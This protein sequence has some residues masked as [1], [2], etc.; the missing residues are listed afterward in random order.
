MSANVFET[1]EG[2][3]AVNDKNQVL[4]AGDDPIDSDDELDQLMEDFEMSES[5]DE[6]DGEQ[7]EKLFLSSSEEEYDEDG[8]P[9]EDDY[10]DNYDFRDA[11]RSAGNFRVKNKSKT[12][13]K[14]TKS[15]WKRK[16]MRSTNRELDPEVRQNLSLAN[17]A[18]V[19]NDFQVA[20]NLYLEVIKKDPK[21]FSA[22]KTLGEIY[23]QEGRLNKCCNYW[24]LAANIHPWDSQFWSN[25]AEL[26]TELGHID[27]AIYCYSRAINSNTSKS[28]RYI[29]ERAILYREKKQYGRALEG[30][31]RVRQLYPTD[32]NIVK[33]LASVYVEQK[34]I[35]DAIN[36]Y[37][38]IL[39][40]NINPS[41]TNQAGT[42]Q[43]KQPKFGWAELN[44]LLELYIQQH[45]WR[46]GIKVTKIVARW[47]QDR[48]DEK[49]WD[50]NDDDS[51]FDQKRRFEFIDKLSDPK[52]RE[53]AIKK[54][55]DLPIDIRFKIGTLRLG[56]GH[57]DEAMRH[58]EFLL[59]E[60]DD[61]SDLYFETGKILE[62]NGYFEDALQFLIKA[63]QNEE[64]E[65]S[66]ELIILL[67]K[68]FLETEDYVQAKQAYES[69]LSIDK[70]NLDY[71]ISL[72][73][74]EYHLGNTEHARILLVEVAAKRGK[75]D[76]AKSDK[77]D[78]ESEGEDH[79]MDGD[80]DDILNNSSL[81]R[82]EKLTAR[83]KK[84]TDQE[85]FEFENNAKKK[86]LE[87]YRSMKRLE[88]SINSEA[89]EKIAIKTWIQLAYQLLE[90][91][92]GV[93]SFFPRDK[94]RQFKGII[95]YRRKQDLG[96]DEKLA[97]VYNLYAGI[98]N[99]GNENYS[100]QF[101]TSKVEYRGISYDEWFKIFTQYAILVLN[102]DHDY[103]NAN[104]MIEISMNVS[105]FIQ[106][107]VK[108]SMLRLV[109]LI[110]GL[111][112]NDMNIITTFIR[113]FLITN[114]FS[115]FIYK[116]FMCCF[117]SGMVSW[118]HFTNYNHQ[119]FFLRQLK[120]FDSIITGKKIVGM[121]TITSDVKDISFKNDHID[122]LYV[123]ANLLGGSRSYI[124]SIV[125]LNRAY[126][127]YNQD[128][129][130]CLM[131]GLAHVHRSMQRLSTNRHLQLLQGVSYLLEYKEATEKEATDYELQ[132]VQYNFGRFFHMIG[133]TS[134]AV[135]FYEKVL[136]FNGKIDVA[137]DLSV[138]AAY[139]L[140]LIYNINGNSLLAR[141]LTE[142][143]L[144]I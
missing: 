38:K 135:D 41:N 126:K 113:Y 116:F 15:Y 51:E 127:E 33:N 120:A 42:P 71:K 53:V 66:T 141:D 99:D 104:Q 125:Y 49:W 100:R 96:I 17:E 79:I 139:N 81:I 2:N 85:R 77:G 122:L 98:G 32:S 4:V 28:S 47:I 109:K 80:H 16:M 94:N 140:A 95:L 107:K 21:N 23:K 45:S 84:L 68:C 74:A 56:L 10:G 65:G 29:L 26:S 119:K 69:L 25:V 92:I 59:D 115:P 93:K 87:K 50:D 105:V 20:M 110:I 12:I 121:A 40:Y 112:K 75:E 97:R 37:M 101:L 128:P 143:Y 134:L 142:K 114:Q 35:N 3:S 11:L 14:S 83:S 18:F 73:E 13:T 91:F 133:L 130:V 123:Y 34:R 54:F 63:A 137:Y 1:D 64:F 132:E 61:I 82:N 124:S 70:D 52:T 86:V 88:E 89:D 138:E 7:E 19:R 72:A 60:T 117:S 44:I 36:L 30:F 108:E 9:I 27:Q 62:E 131:L 55:Y 8:I 111:K 144:T 6:D 76:R 106:D 31:Q 90:I 46:N 39:D 118:E 78:A 43:Q 102:Y 22:Y 57:K 103:E 24:L 67:G 58:F 5:D 136:E 129:M 48:T